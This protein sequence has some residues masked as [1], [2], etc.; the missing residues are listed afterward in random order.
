MNSRKI[1][2]SERVYKLSDRGDGKD[3]ALFHIVERGANHCYNTRSDVYLPM[4]KYDDNSTFS[5]GGAGAIL[6]LDYKEGRLMDNLIIIHGGGPTAVLNC[7]LYGAMDD[8]GNVMD[9]SEGLIDERR[10]T[11]L[12][13]FIRSRIDG[14][15]SMS[16]RIHGR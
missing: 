16:D 11:T 2:Q 8:V 12:M 9:G 15:R 10:K 6:V 4:G 1:T 13:D 3:A 14:I 5:T 7:S